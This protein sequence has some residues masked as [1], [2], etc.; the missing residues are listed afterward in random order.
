LKLHL[1]LGQRLF[2]FT[3]LLLKQDQFLFQRLFVRDYFPS[4]FQP[5]IAAARFGVHAVSPREF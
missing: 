1:F 4:Q 2:Q 5:G 3:D